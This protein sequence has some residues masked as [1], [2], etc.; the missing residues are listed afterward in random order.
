MNSTLV[1]IVEDFLTENQCP[2]NGRLSHTAEEEDGKE[3]LGIR[4]RHPLPRF[5]I[6]LDREVFLPEPLNQILSTS[7]VSFRKRQPLSFIHGIV[8]VQMSSFRFLGDC[9]VH[10]IYY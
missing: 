10:D 6:F 4:N 9:C 8:M 3:N 2:P 1:S 7:L 5:E